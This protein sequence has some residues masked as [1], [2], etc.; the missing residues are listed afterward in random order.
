MSLAMTQLGPTTSLQRQANVV[1]TTI[2]SWDWFIQINVTEIK[3][4]FF[5]LGIPGIDYPIYSSVPPTSFLCDGQVEGGYYA[6]VEAE[7]QD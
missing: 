1:P 6:D 2:Q 3:N 4:K 5:H 7:C